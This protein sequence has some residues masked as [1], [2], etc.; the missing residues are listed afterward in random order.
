MSSEEAIALLAEHGIEFVSEEPADCELS[1]STT[2]EFGLNGLFTVKVNGELLTNEPVDLETL[3]TLL[4]DK[5]VEL[6]IV[7]NEFIDIDP[8][9]EVQAICEASVSE[10][11]VF[12]LDGTFMVKVD[13]QLITAAPADLENIKTVLAAEGL[14]MSIIGVEDTTTDPSCSRTASMT[15]FI[16]L[17][18]LFNAKIDG[19][20]VSTEPVDIDT[21]RTLLEAKGIDVIYE[22]EE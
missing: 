4:N 6:T 14:D 12:G 21:L 3:K 1:E 16:E 7:K 13:G 11:P 19:E 8:E 17:D 5:D 18:G 15:P 2:P 10:T 22:G 9:P 20:Y